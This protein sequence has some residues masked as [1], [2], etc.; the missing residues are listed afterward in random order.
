MQNA[1]QYNNHLFTHAGVTTKVVD[2]LNK[3]H[4]RAY[5]DVLN[6]DMQLVELINGTEIDELFYIGKI[7]GGHDPFSGIFWVRPSQLDKYQLKGYIQHVG[8]TDIEG[9]D[10]KH[11]DSKTLNYYD[12][13]GKYI[14]EI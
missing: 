13:L 2:A 6:G 1:W 4:P 11:L 7:N 9:I 8:H 5:Q 3:R 10:D 12:G 14:I